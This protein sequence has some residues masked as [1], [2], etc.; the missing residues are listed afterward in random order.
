[1]PSHPSV[2]HLDV[3]S[4]DN[5]KKKYKNEIT[6]SEGPNV[7]SYKE[8]IKIQ[9]KSER[10]AAGHGQPG[11]LVQPPVAVRVLAHVHALP[12]FGTG[13]PDGTSRRLVWHS[14]PTP[15]G[16]IDAASPTPSHPR[17]RSWN[18][19][20]SE[21]RPRGSEGRPLRLWPSLFAIM[22]AHRFQLCLINGIVFYI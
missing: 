3:I 9:K 15:H 18:L 1:M 2:P 12:R 21:R 5:E 20:L 7:K 17:S 10:A 13:R 22:Q 11:R 6:S 4:H 19:A 16:D 8:W 14:A